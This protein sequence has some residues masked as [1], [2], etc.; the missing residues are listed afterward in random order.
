MSLDMIRT[1]NVLVLKEPAP[2]VGTS[3]WGQWRG[4]SNHIGGGVVLFQLENI[5]IATIY[6]ITGG[7]TSAACVVCTCTALS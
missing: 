7:P 1:E 4:C 3:S 6:T 2:P 5:D